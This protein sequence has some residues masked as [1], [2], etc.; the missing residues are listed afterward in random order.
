MTERPNP[1]LIDRP[2]TST[3]VVEPLHLGRRIWAAAKD[4]RGLVI[5]GVALA[6]VIWS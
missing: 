5:L 1:N 3:P 6:F 4:W 2:V